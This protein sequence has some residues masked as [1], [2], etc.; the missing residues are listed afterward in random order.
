MIK[1]DILNPKAITKIIKQGLKVSK[2][3]KEIK[4]NH[5]KCSINPKSGKT[6][7]REQKTEQRSF[8]KKRGQF[9]KTYQHH[10]FIYLITASKCMTKG[11]S[12]V[13]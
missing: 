8:I 11:G 10:R 1:V 6:G 5:K 7:K 13:V 3:T 2:S 9:I 12:L 4:W